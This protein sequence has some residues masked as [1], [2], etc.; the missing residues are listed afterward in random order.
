MRPHASRRVL[1]LLVSLRL[2]LLSS[3]AAVL[4]TLWRITILLER[5]LL[6]LEG[7]ASTAA[8]TATTVS[9]S[10]TSAATATEA[11]TSAAVSEAT[12][13]SAATSTATA[14]STA[15]AATAAA[16]TVVWPATSIVQTDSTTLKV[17]ALELL[18]GLLGILNG[19][20][21]DV[22]E[23][24]EPSSFPK[25]KLATCKR[26]ALSMYSLLSRQTKALHLSNVGEESG[27]TLLV[28]LEG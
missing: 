16:T 21:R 3:C 2:L 27:D 18:D 15:T 8:S 28:N 25:R 17:G 10:T 9:K 11:A 13:T 12:A 7:G 5:D 4:V 22:P 23:T 19:V 20:E 24:L 26:R 14:K 6:A 1:L